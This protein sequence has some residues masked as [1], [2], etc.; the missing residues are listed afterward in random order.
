MSRLSDARSHGGFPSA[1]RRAEP[2]HRIALA[3]TVVLAAAAGFVIGQDALSVRAAQAAGPELV[4]VLRFMAAIKGVLA[5][6][7]T[8]LV[9]WRFGYPASVRL[10]TAAIAACALMAAGC[11]VVWCMA[12]IVLGS[13]LFYA[14]LLPLL[15]L[16]YIDRD[17]VF[18]IAETSLKLAL[19]RRETTTTASVRRNGG[20][21]QG[22][23]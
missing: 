13:A 1:P 17:G 6:G 12:H 11:G 15:A 9:W 23:S 21:V 10:T 19:Q 3:A 16:A 20:S 14:G 2:Y 22:G 5:L 4:R 7:A 8:A 18:E